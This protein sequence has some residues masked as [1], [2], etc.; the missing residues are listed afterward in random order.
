MSGKRSYLAAAFSARPFGMPV[1]P[2]W[3]VLGAF[4]LLGAF[5]DPGFW[6]IGAGVEGLYLWAL[7]RNP[8]FRAVIDAESASRMSWDARYRSLADPLDADARALQGTIETL[9]AEIVELLSRSGAHESQIGQVRQMAWL[10]LKLLAARASFLEVIAASRRERGSL[11]QNE[12]QLEAR[13]ERGD[14]DDELRRSLEQQLAVIRSR[15]AAHADAERRRELVDAE[16]ERLRHQVA[17]VR[18]QALLA[19]DEQSVAQS[20]DALSASLNEA[21]RL[22]RDQ[23]ELFAG[24]DELSDEPPPPELLQTKPAASRRQKVSE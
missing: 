5:V 4:G 6:L 16:L 13:L 3:F 14:A 21:N 11:E 15:R 24:L 23:R 2:N 10:H 22:L 19:T 18:E 1:P 17:L 7:S 20:L 8:R 9:A 12:R